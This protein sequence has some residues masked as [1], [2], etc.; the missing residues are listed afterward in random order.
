[1]TQGH[2]GSLAKVK[3]LDT[4]LGK[5]SFTEGRDAD[6]TPVSRWS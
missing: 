1:M 6:H 3:D 5:F 2:P 4:V